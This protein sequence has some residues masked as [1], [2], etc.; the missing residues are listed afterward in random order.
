MPWLIVEGG[1]AVF[2]VYSK[3]HNYPETTKRPNPA[4]GALSSVANH[5]APVLGQG[6]HPR[7]WLN[8]CRHV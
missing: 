8:V 6:G 1:A 4:V 5:P 7:P 2:D 3:D